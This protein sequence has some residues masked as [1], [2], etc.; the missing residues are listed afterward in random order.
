MA[1]RRTARRETLRLLSRSPTFITGVLIIGFWVFC[2]F[3]GERIAPHDPLDQ[4]L[5]QLVPPSSHYLFGTDQLGRDVFSR[6]LAGARDILLIAPA[7]TLL[8]IAGG[9]IIGLIT[10]Y[11]RGYV[12][13]G[14]SRVVDAVLALPLIVIAVTVLVALATRR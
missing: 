5:P 1:Y 11:Y 9:T 12:D 2:A 7:S 8:G 6:V 10:G 13:A 3:F 4:S 14:I